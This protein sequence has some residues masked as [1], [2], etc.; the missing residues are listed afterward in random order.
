[1]GWEGV[2][3]TGF[4]VPTVSLHVHERM[5]V[6]TILSAVRKRNGAYPSA[7]DVAKQTRPI[8]PSLFDQP[9]ENPPLRE[10]LEFYKHSHG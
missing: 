9:V 7:S 4:E 5:D 8:Q 1:V 3:H 6:Q 10:A 2:E